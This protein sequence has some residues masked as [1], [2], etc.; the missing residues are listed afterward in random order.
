[1]EHDVSVVIE[2]PVHGHRLECFPYVP[3]A[4]EKM[5][6]VDIRIREDSCEI[7]LPCISEPVVVILV[8]EVVSADDELFQ[9]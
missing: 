4:E 3:A 2:V 9:K 1:M 7:K 8:Y 6:V 5:G